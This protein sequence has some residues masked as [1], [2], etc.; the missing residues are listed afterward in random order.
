MKPSLDNQYNLLSKTFHWVTFILI[1]VLSVT[2]L[3]MADMPRGP[4]KLDLIDLHGALGFLLLFITICRVLWRLSSPQ[5]LPSAGLSSQTITLSKLVHFTFYGL[6]GAQVILG[7]LSIYTVGRALYFFGLFEIP[8]PLA[9][10]I[11]LHHTM[12]TLHSIGWYTLVALIALHILAVLI[13]HK[14]GVP[15]LRRMT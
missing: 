13:H 1:I 9:R 8:S 12:E 2:G 10:D 4:E 7:M 15:I 11:P 5:P 6:M 3:A 14:N